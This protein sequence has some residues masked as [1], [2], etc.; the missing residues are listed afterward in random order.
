M[1]PEI[2]QEQPNYQNIVPK[3]Y[4]HYPLNSNNAN[5]NNFQKNNN[6]NAMDYMPFKKEPLQNNGYNQH[7]NKEYISPKNDFF[8]KEIIPPV[9]NN[10]K[11][12]FIDKRKHAVSPSPRHRENMI[13]DRNDK[14]NDKANEK[15]NNDRL[16]NKREI[17]PQANN[18][19]PINLI[20][21][22]NRGKDNANLLP[23][24]SNRNKDGPALLKTPYK[25]KEK[26]IKKDEKIN[27]KPFSNPNLE[28]PPME[29]KSEICITEPSKLTK[30]T[31]EQKFEA[32]KNK[33]NIKDK[34]E[35][36]KKPESQKEKTEAQKDK[37]REQER[38]QMM[39][40]IEKKVF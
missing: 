4:A 3:G 38:K 20:P 33:F 39:N 25:E 5:A 36:V 11:N 13:L 22:S 40:D 27:L 21:D 24:T 2:K 26:E 12:D 37:I 30:K 32:L 7:N 6:P 28:K 17:K 16:A 23:P 29:S 34:N 10:Y 8:F 19:K 14:P 9:Q 1:P 15:F 31:S 18:F 35:E